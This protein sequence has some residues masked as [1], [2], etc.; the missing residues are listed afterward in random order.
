MTNT[1]E[2]FSPDFHL[3]FADLCASANIK[4]DYIIELIDYDII[5]PISGK[6]P[7]EWEFNL[8][9]VTIVN[10]AARLHRDLEIDW[11][12][13]ALVLNLL[14][15]IDQLKSE[16]RQLKLQVERLNFTHSFKQ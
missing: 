7:Q 5:M 16:N 10:K 2:I 12:D 3:S 14:E 4:A 1:S 6:I 13:I 8:N 15:E 11:A 9:A